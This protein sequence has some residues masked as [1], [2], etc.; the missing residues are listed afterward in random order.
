[1]SPTPRRHHVL[2]DVRL[3]PHEALEAT[4]G[5]DNEIGDGKAREVDA[6]GK[7]QPKAAVRRL[8]LGGDSRGEAYG[9]DD[10]ADQTSSKKLLLTS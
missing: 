2:S 10:D 8:F 9:G 4:E 7:G 5:A 1:M 6:L 3:C